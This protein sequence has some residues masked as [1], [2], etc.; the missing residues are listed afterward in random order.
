MVCTMNNLKVIEHSVNINASVENVWRV[1]IDVE[2]WRLWDKDVEFSQLMGPFSVG[3]TGK[4]IS[5]DGKISTFFITEIKELS[6]YRN[7]YVYPFFTK[8]NFSHKIETNEQGCKVIFQAGFTGPLAWYFTWKH[9][10]AIKIV[11]ANAMA[12]LT[13][14][15]YQ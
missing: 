4:L 10:D 2:S 15:A 1:L 5:S 3:A 7:Y 11:M 6:Q 14:Y 13:A 12:N 9:R 8:L